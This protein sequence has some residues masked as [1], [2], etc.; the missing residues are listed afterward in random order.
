MSSVSSSFTL[1][2]VLT[3]DSGT[4]GKLEIDTDDVEVA[5]ILRK[6]FGAQDW[7][8]Y[9]K[10]VFSFYSDS[11]EHGD[12]NFFLFDANAG[13]QGSY[14]LILERNAP[15]INRDSLDIGWREIIVDISE[16]TRDNITTVGFYTSTASGWAVE[17]PFSFNINDM[18]LTSGNVFIDRGTSVFKYGNDFQYTFSTLR[19]EASIPTDTFLRARTRV[20]DNEDM[21]GAIWSEFLTT[22]GQDIVLPTAGVYKYIEIEMSFESSSDLVKAPQL[23]SL[24]LDATVTSSDHTF[25]FDNKDSWESGTLFNIDTETNEGSITIKNIGDLGTYVYGQDG[26]LHQLNSDLTEKLNVYGNVVP[27]SFVQML[28]GSPAG[29]GQLSSVVVGLRDSFIVA[30]TD[31]DRV[32]E[33]DKNGAVLWGLMGTYVST[34]ANPYS[35]TAI[36]TATASSD[37]TASSTATEEASLEPLGAYYNIEDGAL[38]VMFNRYLEDIYGS[39]TFKPADMFLKANARRIYLDES[40]FTF[41]LVGVDEEHI[42][43]EPGTEYLAGSNVLQV[44]FSEA[45]AVTISGAA[46]SQDPYLVIVNPTPNKVVTTSSTT[47][48]FQAYNATIGTNDYGIR[49]QVDSEATVDLRLDTELELTS[50]VDGVHVVTATLIDSNGNP[51]ANEGAAS[52]ILFYVETGVLTETV[53]SINSPRGNQILDSGTF[54]IDFDK[55]NVPSGYTLRYSIDSGSSTEYTGASPLNISDLSGG[56]HSI[57]MYYADSSNN[58]LP[59]STADVTVEFVVVSRSGVSFKLFV[60]AGSIKD[61]DGNSVSESSTVV[62]ITNV[63]P[64]NVYSPIDVGLITTESVDGDASEFDVLI[65]K[66]ASPSSLDFTDIAYKDGHSVVQYASTGVLRLSNNDA[67]IASTKGDAKIYLGGAQKYGANELFIADP[68]GRRAMV[69]ELD[70]TNMTSSVIWQYDS[71][72]LISDFNRVPT[73]SGIVSVSSAAIQPSLLYVR[74]DSSVTWYN[75]SNE[76]IRILSGTTTAAQ[77]ALDPDLDLFGDEF[78]S[79]DILPGEYYSSSFLNIGTFDYFVYPF[80][81]TGKVSVIETSITPDDSFILAEN[82][83]SGSSYLNRVIKVD[84]WGNILWSFGESFASLIKS[85]K[86]TDSGEIIITV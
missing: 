42:S 3:P 41:G 79:G 71:D 17:Q 34:P 46:D 8:S 47:I 80:I 62:D 65:A 4:T 84:A 58:A 29:F 23:Y 51:L 61:S 76:T 2:S 39:T 78:D 35:T 66:V 1:D 33:I 24:S 10:I 64:S 11:A 60:S 59:G 16:F 72:K 73:G 69:I 54:S 32:L 15:T 13:S 68:N 44:N 12:I 48:E 21:G 38:Y 37:A 75:N 25:E 6:T 36:S 45:D 9:D 52:T 27:R 40:K 5:F 57:R 28:D 14:Q 86:P 82:D 30:D 22:S 83:P 85:A 63:R 20:S 81:Y 77:F 56:E 67:V 53:I 7:T 49:V 74:R 31:N 26:S 55:Y 19:W 70:Q 18:Y 50:L 43:A